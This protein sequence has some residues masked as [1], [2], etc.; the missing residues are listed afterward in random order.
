MLSRL[1][2]EANNQGIGRAE[3]PK[4]DIFF[5]IFTVQEFWKRSGNGILKSL[6]IVL[7]EPIENSE[8]HEKPN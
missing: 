8:E 6:E 4:N 7:T 1:E 3:W 2:I 5:T